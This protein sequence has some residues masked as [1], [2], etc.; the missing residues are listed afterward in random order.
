LVE[1]LGGDF[2][3]LVYCLLRFSHLAALPLAVPF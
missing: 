3:V 2:L 1:A